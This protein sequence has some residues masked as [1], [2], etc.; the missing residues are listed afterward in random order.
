MQMKSKIFSILAV[1]LLTIIGLF[2]NATFE[3]LEST[4][5]SVQIPLPRK[6][7]WLIRIDANTFW[8]EELYTILFDSKEEQLLQS[9]RNV[10]NKKKHGTG[11]MGPLSIDFQSDLVAYR[12]HRG[13]RQ[14]TIVVVQLINPK[15]FKRNI[16]DYLNEHQAFK[17]V[18]STAFI[19]TEHAANHHSKATLAHVLNDCVDAPLVDFNRIK[20]AKKE[21]ITVQLQPQADQSD[22][23]QLR[24]GISHTPNDILFNGTMYI[25]QAFPEPIPF[26]LSCKGFYFSARF[27]PV[28]LKDSISKYMPFGKSFFQH[29]NALICDY[30]G[31]YLSDEKPGLPAVMGY[32]PLPIMNLIVNFEKP[33][34]IADFYASCP[35]SIQAANYTLNFGEKEYTLIQL[36]PT[37]LFIGTH[38]TSIIQRKQVNWFELKGKPTAVTSIDGNAFIAAFVQGMTPIKV[39]NDFFKN[40]HA[41]QLV[42]KPT[43]ASRAMISGKIGFK[44]NHFPLN[45]ITKLLLELNVIR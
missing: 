28:A 16:S 21:L 41:V 37:T 38:P 24:F 32:M 45:E 43:S 10:M 31:L 1:V 2:L 7:D 30:Q 36:T 5:K 11:K 40:T 34:S 25:K 27:I 26:D 9:L 42:V 22:I 44:Q 3:L 15:V 18:Y 17:V 35:S 6:T 19:I 23:T 20:N 14:F 13:E 39:T 8:K 4:T 33:V 12:I 29:S